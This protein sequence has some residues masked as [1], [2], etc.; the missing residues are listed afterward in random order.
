MDLADFA[1][2][3]AAVEAA[4]RFDSENA[5]ESWATRTCLDTAAVGRVLEELDGTPRSARTCI[6]C[7]HTLVAPLRALNP[8]EE[9]RPIRPFRDRTTRVESWQHRVM[10]RRRFRSMILEALD[11]VEDDEEDDGSPS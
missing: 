8:R 3:E 5:F 7:P 6:E 9:S 10:E 4:W 2:Y 11:G 1:A